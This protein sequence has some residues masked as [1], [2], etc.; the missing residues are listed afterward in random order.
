MKPEM[1]EAI[2]AWGGLSAACTALDDANVRFRRL[3]A[4]LDPNSQADLVR[5]IEVQDL[6]CTQADLEKIIDEIEAVGVGEVAA[7]AVTEAGQ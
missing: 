3:L 5:L 2:K 1:I 6:Y 4:E 7:A